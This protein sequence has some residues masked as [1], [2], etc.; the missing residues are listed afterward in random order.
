LLAL[1]FSSNISVTEIIPGQVV[2]TLTG[3]YSLWDVGSQL[4]ARSLSVSQ[5]SATAMLSWPTV[6]DYRFISDNALSV[7]EP[8]FEQ[9]INLVA[10]AGNDTTFPR[11]LQ[12]AF[13]VLLV[14][15]CLSIGVFLFRP[16]F[17]RIQDD[18]IVTLNMFLQIP[19]HGAFV[20]A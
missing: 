17:R 11:I 19:S 4:V 18:R 5:L 6:R 14:L 9:A 8:M 2:T 20:I 16:L 13:L 7:F 1:E 15:F 3:K 10:Q 12:I